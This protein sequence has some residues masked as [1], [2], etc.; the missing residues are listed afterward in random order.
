MTRETFDRELH[1]LQD[2]VLILGGLVEKAIIQSVEVLKRRDLEGARRLIAQDRRVINEKRF[3]IESGALTLIA[4]QQPM[5]GDL[6]VIAAV[7]EI[8]HELERM[9]DYAKGI[10]KINLMMGDEPLLKP[11][12]DIPLM[13]E[14]ARSMLHQAL[15]AFVRRDVEL[16]RTIPKQDDEV[17][18]LYNQVYRD[19][20]AL[21]MQNPRDIDRATYLLWVAHNLERTADR[22]ANICE[23]VIFMVT[24]E[25]VEMD[26][27][28]RSMA[29]MR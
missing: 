29:S 10:A 27:D 1:R 9:G 22:V 19:L 20:L 4:T 28:D 21:M 18:A 8:A 23:R 16:A 25:M 11:L 6:R 12:V 14:K 13:A 3:A 24:G 15:E 7:L 2:E 17:D 5:A 26:V